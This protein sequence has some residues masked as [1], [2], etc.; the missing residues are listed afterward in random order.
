LSL[1]WMGTVGVN[2]PNGVQLSLDG[3]FLLVT[4]TARGEL[5]RWNVTA[6]GALSN[7]VILATGLSVADGMCTDSIGNIYVTVASGVEIF[8]VDGARWGNVPIPRMAANCAFGD[9]DG[10]S[11]YVTARQG[12]YRVR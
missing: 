5:R 1:E 11:L 2:Q 6:S 7:P 9:S 8:T 4:D 3:G 10:R 12:L